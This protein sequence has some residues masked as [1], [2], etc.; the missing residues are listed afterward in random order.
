MGMF[1]PTVRAALTEDDFFRDDLG[2]QTVSGQRVS[3]TTSTRV[4]VVLRCVKLLT[5][6]IATLSKDVV[7]SIGGQRYTEFAKPDWLT[8]PV[9]SDPS[10][11][12]VEHFSQVVGAMALHGDSFTFVPGGIHPLDGIVGRGQLEVL[13]PR[14]VNVKR[15]PRY[16]IL[17]QYGKVIE[18]VGPERM[19]HVSWYRPAGSLRGLSPIEEARQAIGLALGTEEFAA[20]F[21]GQGATMAIGLEVPGLL[22]EKQRTDLVTGLEGLYAGTRKA[23]RIGVVT[24]GTKFVTGLGV[25]NDQAQFLESRKF[26]VE[27]IAR[28]FGVPP[29]LVGSQ[30]PGASSYSSVEQRSLEFAKFNIAPWVSRITAQYSRLVSVPTRLEGSGASARFAMDLRSLERADIKTRY[31]AYN[32]AVGGPWLE[33]NI[34]RALEDLAPIEGGDKIHVQSQMVPLGTAPKEQAA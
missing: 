13:D 2:R 32:L 9:P 10:M 26:S 8:N 4:T 12:D 33:P 11:T 14:H 24:G 6:V 23:H 28:L 34:P 20:R 5:D 18:T 15:G 22:D 25:S 1:S 30:E 17:D 16:D 3:A 7:I 27:D 29:H 21:F 19:L 31:E